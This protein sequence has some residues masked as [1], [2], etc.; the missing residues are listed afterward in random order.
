MSIHLG[1]LKRVDLREFFKDESS[2]WFLEMTETF[3]K[4]FSPRVKQL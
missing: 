2:D 1:R 4:V 3:H